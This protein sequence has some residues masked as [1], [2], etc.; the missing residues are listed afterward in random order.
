[1]LLASAALPEGIQENTGH[2][3]FANIF[4]PSFGVK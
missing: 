2:W 1:V 4:N 3:Q